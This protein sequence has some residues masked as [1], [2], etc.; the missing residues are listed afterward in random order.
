MRARALG[1]ALGY[2]ADRLLGDPARLHPVAGFGTTAAAVERRLYADSR[3]RGLVHT[4]VLAGGAVALGAGAQ[5]LAG[6]PAARVLVTA[7]ATWVVL[8]GRSL[9]GEAVAVGRLLEGDDL[10]AARQRLT[11]L[12]GRDTRRL[13]PTEI[14][15]AVVE[16][17]AENTSDA[18]VAPLVWGAVAGVPGLLG[19]RATNTLD[20]MVGHRNDRYQRY[21]WASA[22]LDDL[23]NL[24]ASRLTALL[25]VALGGDPH[26]AWRAW[27]RD[28]AGHPSPNAGVVEA[29]FAGALGVRLGGTNTY[30]GGRIEHRPVTSSG[31]PAQAADISRATVLARRVGHGA[32]LAAVAFACST[33]RAQSSAGRAASTWSHRSSTRAMFQ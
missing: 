23:V 6:H 14:S 3:A 20:A 8:G 13:G 19:H 5:R 32:A 25:A 31:R 9:E 29:S 18:V 1:L 10:V 4:A 15:R 30:D 7:V 28:A 22:R 16:S 12:V 17:V 24:P 21:G 11:H 33:R 26:A 27:H 2:A